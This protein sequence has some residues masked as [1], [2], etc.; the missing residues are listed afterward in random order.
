M[1]LILKIAIVMTIIFFFYKTA[2]RFLNPTRKLYSS[3]KHKQFFL[4]DERHNARKNFSLTYKGLLF[5]GEKYLRNRNDLESVSSILISAAS[6]ADANSVTKEDLLFIE[7]QI[8]LHYPEAEVDWEE[9]LQG[10]SVN[11]ALE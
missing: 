11:Q 4:L 5:E 8:K 9:P 7:E 3:Q 10:L 2:K 1:A 6:P